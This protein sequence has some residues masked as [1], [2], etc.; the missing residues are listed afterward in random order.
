MYLYLLA[1]LLCLYIKRDK[2]LGVF[3]SNPGMRRQ[4]LE[5]AIKT[6]ILS[7]FPVVNILA[8]YFHVVKWLW[9]ATVVKSQTKPSVKNKAEMDESQQTQQESQFTPTQI[10]H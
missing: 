7:F 5:I 4:N 8:V 2:I 3:C 6:I 9:V 10:L 1:T